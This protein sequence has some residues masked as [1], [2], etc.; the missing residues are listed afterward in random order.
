[1]SSFCSAMEV[2]SKSRG[3][4]SIFILIEY[5]CRFGC[6]AVYFGI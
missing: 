5:Y 2:Y 6:D 4:D 3:V 1:V